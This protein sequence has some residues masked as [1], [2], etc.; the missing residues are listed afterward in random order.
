MRFSI[1]SAGRSFG[2]RAIA[3]V[4]GLVAG[5]AA[6]QSGAN[7]QEKAMKIRIKVD[8]QVMTARLAD[9]PSAKDFSAMLPL[10]VTLKDYASTE[11][12]TYLPRKLS[13]QD[14]PP[15]HDPSVGDI[16]YYA[17]WGNIAIFYKDFSYS[18][19]LISLGKIESGAELLKPSSQDIKAVIELAD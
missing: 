6:G 1:G 14:A 11:K 3:C 19:G 5:H 17:P 2:Y 9:N 16:A 10:T 13:T 18:A 4:L 8:G 12:I 7:Q 15:G